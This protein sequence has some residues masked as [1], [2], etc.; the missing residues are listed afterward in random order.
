MCVR[1]EYGRAMHG[2]EIACRVCRPNKE[3]R[4]PVASGAT[5]KHAGETQLSSE[6][7]ARC[8]AGGGGN[9]GGTCV[10]EILLTQRVQVRESIT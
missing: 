10:T 9:G 5:G 8:G 4:M 7:V 6:R 1:Y 2:R 3:P